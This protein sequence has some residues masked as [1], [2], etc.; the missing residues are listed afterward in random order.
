MLGT[1]NNTAT[2][3]DNPGVAVLPPV[4]YGGALVAVLALHW[5][6]PMPIFGHAVAHWSGL[7]FIVFAVAIAIWGRRTMHAAG[8]NVNP[9]RPAT[10]VTAASVCA[11]R[12]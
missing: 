6:W 1:R 12:A 10:A 11:V 8:T 4:L 2:L 5:F 3:A 9:L 7:A